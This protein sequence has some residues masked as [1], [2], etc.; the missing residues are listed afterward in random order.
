MNIEDQWLDKKGWTGKMN[1][2]D[3]KLCGGS[4]VLE[5]LSLKEAL[6]MVQ[7]KQSARGEFEEL[8]FNAALSP[9]QQ[10]TP[11]ALHDVAGALLREPSSLL[12]LGGVRA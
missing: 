8:Y 9:L 6:A 2:G 7:Q 1:A 5:K 12:L 4:A 10:R 11:S 3:V